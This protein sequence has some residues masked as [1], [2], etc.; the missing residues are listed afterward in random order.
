[1]AYEVSNLFDRFG[2]I[3]SPEFSK[4]TFVSQQT[5]FIAGVTFSFASIAACSTGARGSRFGLSVGGLFS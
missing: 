3:P 2:T 4:V 5:N 1:M